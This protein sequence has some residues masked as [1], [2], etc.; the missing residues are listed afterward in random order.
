MRKDIKLLLARVA[1]L[2]QKEA[3]PRAA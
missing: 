2:E 3:T 1:T